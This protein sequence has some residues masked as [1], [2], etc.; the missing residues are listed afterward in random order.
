MQPTL[1]RF[2]AKPPIADVESTYVGIVKKIAPQ[3]LA[4]RLSTVKTSFNI[5]IRLIAIE[6]CV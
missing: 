2:A 6:N 3:P 1:G 5:S 4:T